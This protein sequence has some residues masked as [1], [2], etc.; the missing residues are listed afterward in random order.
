[1]SHVGICMW[2]WDGS[3][4]EKFSFSLWFTFFSSKILR[5][6]T[7]R[8]I[9][10]FEFTFYACEK[11]MWSIFRAEIKEKLNGSN[12]EPSQ[13]HMY[14]IYRISDMWHWLLR[15]HFE[16]SQ[17][18]S[19]S[20]ILGGKIYDYLYMNQS[21]SQYILYSQSPIFLQ[22]CNLKFYGQNFD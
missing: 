13:D 22:G 2:S 21:Q 9:K 18:T 5:W 15:W 19:R 8:S 17:G 6:L 3:K 1:M 12:F 16:L 7:I 20:C 14:I 11:S 10:Y 4:F